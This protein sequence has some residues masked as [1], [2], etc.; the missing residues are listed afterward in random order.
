MPET[1][2]KNF[3]AKA[4]KALRGVTN[5]AIHFALPPGIQYVTYLAFT[6]V[7]N[8]TLLHSRLD[9]WVA[10]IGVT[11]IAY[12]GKHF[13]RQL[14]KPSMFDALVEL[15]KFSALAGAAQKAQDDSDRPGAYL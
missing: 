11:A 14:T 10:A 6:Q 13:H 12:M 4:L 7:I 8:V 9:S 2:S 1:A 5:L 15:A 3:P